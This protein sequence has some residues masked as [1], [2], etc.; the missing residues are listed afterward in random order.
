MKKRLQQLTLTAIA[1]IFCCYPAMAYDFLSGGIPYKITNESDK[2]VEVTYFGKLESN[3][4]IYQNWLNYSGDIEIPEKVTSNGVEYTVTAIGDYAVTGASKVTSITIPDC[5]TSIGVGAFATC[6]G[7]TSVSLGNG[8]ETIKKEAFHRVNVLSQITLPASLT[9]IG[10]DAFSG[11][12]LTLIVSLNE[13]PPT[14]HEN[15]FRGIESATVK[16]PSANAVDKYK[17]ATGWKEFTTFSYTTVITLNSTSL[18]LYRNE[19]TQ[20]TATVIPAEL[21]TLTWSSSNT[22]VATVDNNELVTAKGAGNATISATPTFFLPPTDLIP[23]TTYTCEVAVLNKFNFNDAYFGVVSEE[24]KE[25][26]ISFAG[27]TYDEV[28]NE[29]LGSVH[30]NN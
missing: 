18:R 7:L 30:L 1:I 24:D 10:E 26:E 19:T 11:S 20:L 28:D 5:V 27:T 16:L 25:L 23:T 15:A 6:N 9:E 21:A 3:D 12:G 14:A 8:I 17:N 2:T 29:Y 4:Y 22:S 13:T